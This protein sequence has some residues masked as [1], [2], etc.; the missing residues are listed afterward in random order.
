M[1][2]TVA[3]QLQLPTREISMNITGIGGHSS[4]IVGLAESIPF[5]IDLEDNKAANFFIV[6][7]KV[8]T[9]LGR[10]FLAD[11]KVRLEWSK[12]RG[13]ILSYE[14]WD[15][16]RLC[17]PI[18]AP[19]VPGWEMGPPRRITDKC[20]HSIRVG[21]YQTSGTDGKADSGTDGQADSGTDGQADS[22]TDGQAD[23]GT[24]RQADSGT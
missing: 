15:G 13:E 17:I 3:L 5:Y 24:D 8:Y 11:H 10:P 1:P 23:S 20:S 4:P 19:E 16:E 7:G 18:C 6:Q 2:E 9:V 22:R 21:Q 12:S 14:L